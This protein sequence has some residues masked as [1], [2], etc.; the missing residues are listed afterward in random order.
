MPPIRVRNTIEWIEKK[1]R[2]KILRLITL[3][4]CFNDTWCEMK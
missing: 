1:E 3:R 2:R 4:G